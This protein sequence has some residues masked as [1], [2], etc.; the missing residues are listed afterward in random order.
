MDCSPEYVADAFYQS[1]QVEGSAP[2]DVVAVDE[3]V[4]GRFFSNIF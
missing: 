3:N 1:N 4:N 2:D